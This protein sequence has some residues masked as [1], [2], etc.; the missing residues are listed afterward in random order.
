[1]ES[2][3]SPLTQAS[4]GLQRKHMKNKGSSHHVLSI[5][6]TGPHT[7]SCGHSFE[8]ALVGVY[9][10]EHAGENIPFVRGL[11]RKSAEEVCNAVKSI[12]AEIRCIFGDDTL[13][14]KVHSDAG[15]EFINHQMETYLKDQGIWQ[16]QTA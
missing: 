5:D 3:Q 9:Y 6:L 4:R 14:L 2:N 1:M 7:P 11:K 16:T 8:Y 12:I 10:V 15:G 13:I